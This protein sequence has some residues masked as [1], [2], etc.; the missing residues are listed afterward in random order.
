[1]A[2]LMAVHEQKEESSYETARL[3]QKAVDVAFGLMYVLT[4]IMDIMPVGRIV[5]VWYNLKLQC[6]YILPSYKLTRIYK[7]SILNI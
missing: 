3:S 1:M 4:V 2:V 5:E 6:N 7:M